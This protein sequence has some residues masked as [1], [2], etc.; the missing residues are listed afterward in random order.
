M[1][2]VRLNR[3]LREC[4]RN[5]MLRHCFQEEVAQLVQ[6]RAELARRVYE[7]VFDAATRAKMEALPDGWLPTDDNIQARFSG[8]NDWLPFNGTFHGELSLVRPRV[9]T[10]YRRFPSAKRG[11]CLEVYDPSHPLAEEHEE[12]SRRMRDVAERFAMAKR[13]VTAAL[14]RPTT[15]N[16]LKELWP[17]AAP[18]VK[19][20]ES[21]PQ[22]LPISE[23]NSILNLEAA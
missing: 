18:F 6:D 21:P 16:R 15:L 9:E 22:L 12:L 19:R 10:V 7:D 23:L 1:A 13:Q 17:E 20:Y 2:T 3:H 8:S 4:I 11:G 5:E 14:E